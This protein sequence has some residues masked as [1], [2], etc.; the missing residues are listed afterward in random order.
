VLA[1][2]QSVGLV[3]MLGLVGLFAASVPFLSWS[4]LGALPS[5]TV[6]VVLSAATGLGSLRRAHAAS[7]L[8]AI[9]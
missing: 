5:T 6:Y 3:R 4:L 9:T 1:L 8:N 7:Y 2:P